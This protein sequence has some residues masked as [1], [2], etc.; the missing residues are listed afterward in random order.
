MNG[1][2]RRQVLEAGALGA[3]WSAA[4]CRRSG[5]A[6][7]LGATAAPDVDVTLRA[8]GGE[9]GL[10]P[11]G[12][13]TG[14]WR[15]AGRSSAP[16]LV[17]G[18]GGGYLGPT[19]RARAG[20]RV[21]LAFDN[22]LPEPSI[23]HFH[24][25]DVADTN[26]GHPRFAIGSGGRR[27]YDFVVENR[28]GT[29]WY[30]P[31]PDGR[32][33]EQVYRGLAGLFV[34]T[35]PDDLVRGLPSEE[36]ELPLVIQDRAFDGDG[37]LVYAAN[38]MFGFLGDRVLVNGRVD[39]AFDVRKGSYRLRVL[40]GSNARIYKLAWSDRRP[41]RVIGTDGG[42]VAA[43]LERPFV[44][45]GPGERVELWADF[46]R[47]GDVALESLAFE[48][49]ARPMG[50]MRGGGMM[51]HMGGPRGA[52]ANGAALRV[53]RFVVRG[54]GAAL[55][56]PRELAR[57]AWRPADEVANRDEPRRFVVS[58]GMMRWFLNGATFDMDGVAANERVKLGATEDWE[59]V[60]AG[61]M[62]T[63]THPIH[64]HGGQFQIVSRDVAPQWADVAETMT[65]GLVDDGWKDTFLLRPGER[66]R[67]RVRF[68]RHAGLFLYH[69]HNLEHE[70]LGMMRNFR[71]EV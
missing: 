42:L 57:P 8:E 1:P 10:G 34:V 3:L 33:G 69:C 66:V 41:V 32:T 48:V 5:P 44:M 63:M 35:D 58:M 38:P 39:A 17:A 6:G 28:P 52:L 71:V 62:M 2:T 60:N 7:A 53:C 26:D 9:V 49:G 20:Q 22:A 54:A 16:G 25:L 30:H 29:Y 64:I 68:A 15:F 4:G 12:R 40:N 45:L 56:L 21:R 51:G 13:P 70:D 27:R 14:V 18:S 55:P 43:P 37:Q 59:F 46:E 50:G 47:G 23:V 11:S 19:F 24:G 61:G 31:H 36:F 67:L 65:A